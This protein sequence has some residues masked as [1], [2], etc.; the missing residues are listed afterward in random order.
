[1]KTIVVGY[2]DTDAAK[3]ALERAADLAAAFGSTLVVT[4]VAPVLMPAGRGTGGVDPTDPPSRHVEE[5]Q[6]A[7]EYL[8]GRGI[9]AEYVP[10]V[11]DPA[12]TIIEAA[13]ERGADTI[14]VGTRELGTL[15]RLLGASVS[16]AVSRRAHC[17]V[18]IVH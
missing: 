7:R 12:D 15:E 1:M 6:H 18:L 14:V 13:E 16:G 3:R 4:S 9:E 5:L 8:S 2:D 17:D 10:G 11:G